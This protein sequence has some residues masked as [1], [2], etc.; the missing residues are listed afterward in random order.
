MNMSDYTAAGALV[1]SVVSFVVT[2][3]LDRRTKRTELRLKEEEL[4][5]HQIARHSKHFKVRRNQLA[6]PP[7]TLLV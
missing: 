6:L 3:S 7:C 2:L 5:L 4:K 1:F